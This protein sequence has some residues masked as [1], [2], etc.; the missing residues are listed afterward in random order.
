LFVAELLRH[1]A[2]GAIVTLFNGVRKDIGKNSGFMRLE[3]ISAKISAIVHATEDADRVLQALRQLFPEGSLPSK[4]ESRRFDGHYG[5]EIRI[6]DL[7]I[8]GASA[9]LFL[10]YLWKNLPSL[11]RVS[12][13]EAFEKHI[14]DSGG[15]HLRL[16]KE[17]V[18]L[19]RLR[20]KDQD[21]IKIHLSF[22]KEIKSN[23]NF[24]RGIKQL[25][26]SLEDN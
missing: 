24:S 16:D 6:V 25:L 15:L 20:M 5:N 18:F 12:L 11:D 2:F 3:V 9:R 10:K 23:L 26:E 21:P 22:R 19:G 4:A 14:D 13:L 1:F 17:E 8:R 7:S